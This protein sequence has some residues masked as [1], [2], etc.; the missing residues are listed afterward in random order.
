MAAETLARVEPR[1]ATDALSSL[2]SRV[3]VPPRLL[4]E[5]G[6]DQAQID[7]ILKAAMRAPD[8]GNL[9]PVRFILVRGA[10]RA[11]LGDLFAEATKRREPM[12]EEALLERMRTW[13]RTTPLT[14]ALVARTTPEHKIP[15]SEQMLSAAAS[16]ANILNA[17]HT[18]GYAGMWVTGANAYDPFVQKAL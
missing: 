3:S 6:P 15:V 2:L 13:P 18:F 5:P 8:H 7:A 4:V 14:V 1:D 12:A 10:A 9:K 16:G 11:K 17:M